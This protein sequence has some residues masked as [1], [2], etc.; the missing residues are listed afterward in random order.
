[1]AILFRF[2]EEMLEHHG[3]YSRDQGPGRVPRRSQSKRQALPVRSQRESGP[4]PFRPRWGGTTSEN[5]RS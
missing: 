2:E 4:R 3:L 1:M 5:Q